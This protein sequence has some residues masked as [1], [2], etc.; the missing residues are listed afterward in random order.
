MNFEITIGINAV[1]VL[2]EKKPEEIE[3][4]L[5]ISGRRNRRQTELVNLARLRNVRVVEVSK[6]ELEGQ[7]QGTHQGVAAFVNKSSTA[8]Q[9]IVSAAELIESVGKR[10][11]ELLLV[12]DSVTDPHNLGA[13]LRTADAAGVRFVITPKN[14]SALLNSTARKIA[15]GAAE[16]VNL[17]AVTNLAR[18]LTDLKQVGF[19]IIGTDERATK[20]IYQQDF[21]GLVVLVMGSEGTGLRRLTREKCDFL[22]SI[23]MAGDLSSLNV[24]VAAG[25][26]LFEA[27]RQ[28]SLDGG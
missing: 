10:K 28:R 4:L 27:V 25:V 23:P 9:G 11:S 1:S 15:S 3:R 26:T 24:S 16:T 13:C 21:R 17:L 6:E 18:F 22:A 19:W 14:N 8:P 2:L 5:I 20:T 7:V 12:L